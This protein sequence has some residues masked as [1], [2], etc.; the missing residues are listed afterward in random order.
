MQQE[1]TEANADEAN[2]VDKSP[3]DEKAEVAQVNEPNE[4]QQSQVVHRVPGRKSIGGTANRSAKPTTNSAGTSFNILSEFKIPEFKIP[5]FSNPFASGNKE[6]SS[7]EEE[8]AKPIKIPGLK[9][10][11]V[12]SPDSEILESLPKLDSERAEVPG[13]KLMPSLTPKKVPMTDEEA[14]INAAEIA[15]A[16]D[17]KSELGSGLPVAP[18]ADDEKEAL[19]DP[20]K[21]LDEFKK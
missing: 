1:N 12:P 14:A 21:I 5:E 4:K 9:N 20:D 16:I 18:E 2:A 6:Q 17:E 10:P 7:A 8:T 11:V 19:V 3:E 13:L 15:K